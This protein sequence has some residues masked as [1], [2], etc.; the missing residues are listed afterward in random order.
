MELIAYAVFIIILAIPFL[1][2]AAIASAFIGGIAA[3]VEG[4][5]SG[6]SSRAL[7]GA[8]SMVASGAAAMMIMHWA[9]ARPTDTATSAHRIVHQ[10]YQGLRAHYIALRW[11]HDGNLKRVTEQQRARDG[12]QRLRSTNEG[13]KPPGIQSSPR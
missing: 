2:I 5:A 12:E 1:V 4:L 8:V 9:T 7:L 11:L 13:G 6:R 10:T 3:I